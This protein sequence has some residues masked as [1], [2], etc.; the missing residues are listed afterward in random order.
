M[1]VSVISRWY[2]EEF[3]APFF[4][5]HYAWADEIIVLLEKST[6]DKSAEIIG[7]YPNARIEYS[8]HGGVLNDRLL[9]DMMS[10]WAASLESDWV[11]RADADEF[12]FPIGFEDPRVVL[13]RADGNVI[14]TW[15]RWIY[16]HATDTDLDPSKPA[17]F[18]RRHGGPY[19]IYPGRGDKF[20]KPCIVKPE[21]KVRWH[22]G[23]ENCGASPL[24]QVSS[25][26][27]DGVHWQMV[28]VEVAIR[29]N[30]S[31]DRRLSAENIKNGWGVK[32]FTEAR[33]RAECA[34]HL[35]DPQVF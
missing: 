29:R 22:P 18:Q 17:M 25:T 14:N 30:A 13:A 28:D 10:D 5:S 23:E 32:N 6:T 15:Y 20:V 3:F 11:I 26:T 12:A 2:N 21:A 27:F 16:R 1:R 4:L 8:D 35:H 31:N 19:T 24:I 7:R 34:A 33:I 9:S